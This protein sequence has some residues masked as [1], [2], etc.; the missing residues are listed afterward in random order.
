[1]ST[2]KKLIIAVVALSLALCCA[3]GGTLAWLHDETSTV[4][5]T[6]TYGDINIA[7]DESDD[8]DLQMIPGSVITKDPY[9][10]V[11]AG[12]EACYL[13]LKV[14]ESA[15]LRDYVSY[16]LYDYWK[17]LTGVDG[18]YYMEV[19]ADNAS[20]GITYN[21]IVDNEVTVLESVTK[22]M[23]EAVKADT[24]LVQLSFTAYAVQKENVPS[25]E[26]AWEIANGG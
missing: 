16:A 6:F 24:D 23:M 19:S 20:A 12:S 25:A 7:L 22:E 13:F 2:N 9:V 10:T 3:V 26:K 21:V 15:K 8:L 1:M 4:T 18:V 11:E 5:N 17:P 14:E